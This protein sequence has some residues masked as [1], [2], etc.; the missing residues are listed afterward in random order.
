M[1]SRKK[2]QARDRAL[3]DVMKFPN[4]L[5]WSTFSPV[6]RAMV[7]ADIDTKRI[8]YEAAFDVV[9]ER[10]AKAAAHLEAVR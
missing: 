10:A 9:L 5:A 4:F 6:A 8:A 1:I 2:F 3:I 7:S